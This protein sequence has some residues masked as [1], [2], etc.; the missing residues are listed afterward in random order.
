MRKR[1]ASLGFAMAL[2]PVPNLR[3]VDLDVI[4][5]DGGMNGHRNGTS[6]AA[7]RNIDSNHTAGRSAGR[8]APAAHHP[9]TGPSS[10]FGQRPLKRQRV[11]SPLPNN[12]HIEQ[13]SSRDAMPPPQKPLSRTRSV[14]KIFPT[15]RKKFSSGRSTEA[16]G[17]APRQ[18]EDVHMYEGGHW[19]DTSRVPANDSQASVDHNDFGSASH[20]MSGALP[21]MSS[22]QRP[23][24]R[25][26]KLLSNAG[27]DND[28]AGFTFRAPSPVK[29]KNRDS[30]LQ[31]VQL[32][33][34]PSYIQLMDGL[35]RDNGFELGLKD[36][37]EKVHRTYHDTEEH[38]Q[39]MR[40]GQDFR[41]YES[42]GER[43]DWSHGLPFQHHLTREPSFTNGSRLESKRE[44]WTDHHHDRMYPEATRDPVTPA[45]RKYSQSG[46]QIESV[47][48]PYVKRISRNTPQYPNHWIAEP[49]HSSTHSVDY[50]SRRFPRLE[51]TARWSE[52]KGLNSLSFF[53]SPVIPNQPAQQGSQEREQSTTA[54][55]S[56][57]YQSRNLNSSGFITR[58]QAERSPFFRD[59]AYGSSRDR[60]T[61]FDHHN[62]Q[63]HSAIPFPSIRRSQYSRIGR[64]LSSMPSAVS[65]RLPVR[66]Q[67]QWKALQPMGVR[68]SQQNFSESVGNGFSLS[69]R[70]IVSS[71]GRRNVRR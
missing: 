18:A 67:P 45:P 62:S 7:V 21:V 38:R 71:A 42:S 64:V 30:Q 66:T 5:D 3:E 36:P 29:M 1:L 65:S 58:P 60:P 10:P 44:P 31:P 35:S 20:Y 51:P 43:G 27:A 13:P 8:S 57:H 55:P 14:R 63:S 16:F 61:H 17:Q 33:T 9:F 41:E 69:A 49:Q 25:G 26:T 28:E 48:S 34:E 32:P 40:D 4:D 24:Q 19:K 22:S 15:L 47:V 56:R 53:D 68:S 50:R 52:P 23:R 12:M 37:R 11:D 6:R 70:D 39:V 2:D 54:P 59:S 46:Q